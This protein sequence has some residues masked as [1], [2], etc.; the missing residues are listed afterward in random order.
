VPDL[1]LVAFQ[2]DAATAGR[3]QMRAL[4]VALCPEAADALSAL[5]TP[6]ELQTNI[7]DHG[8]LESAAGE[9]LVRFEQVAEL[10]RVAIDRQTTWRSLDAHYYAVLTL[11]D[12]LTFAVL[13]LR[14]L[15]EMHR[16]RVVTFFRCWPLSSGA[17]VPG[18]EDSIWS[19]LCAWLAEAPDD[20][21]PD[22]ARGVRW[23]AV[24]STASRFGVRD[25]IRRQNA[26][27]S[28]LAYLREVRAL[29][30]RIRQWRAVL[31]VL[32]RRPVRAARAPAAARMLVLGAPPDIGVIREA[33]GQQVDLWHWE[34]ETPAPVG[35]PGRLVLDAP[36]LIDPEASARVSAAVTRAL[37]SPL[38]TIHGV[39]IAAVGGPAW[40]ALLRETPRTFELFRS[41]QAYLAAL[42]PDLIVHGELGMP[43]WTRTMVEAAWSLGL[44][45]AFQQWGGNYGYIDQRYLDQGELRSNHVLAYTDHVAERLTRQVSAS[46]QARATIHVGG[47]PYL[48]RERE[49]LRLAAEH[50][51]GAERRCVYVPAAFTGSTRYGPSH[52]V[53]DSLQYQVQQR[54]VS[55]LAAVKRPFVVKLTPRRRAAFEPLERSIRRRHLPVSFDRRP[56]EH[57]LDT[58]A[59]WIVDGSATTLQQVLLS[60]NPVIFVDT[61][62]TRFDAG[63]MA[64]L[65][66]DAVV[67][68]A[69][70]V[71]FVDALRDAV[72]DA[73]TQPWQACGE[74]VRTYGVAAASAHDICAGAVE[75]LARLAGA[76]DRPVHA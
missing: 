68:D 30:G 11:M 2:E 55:A 46:R 65:Q 40:Q 49:R 18:P 70:D 42:A 52:A 9:N 7:D 69:W 29:S 57:V 26:D 76:P 33:L 37:A 21:R 58:P 13:Q 75:V 72:L 3:N 47:A 54:V 25:R 28:P 43:R 27:G 6:Y 44:P 5:G 74:F 15:V 61:R 39:P 41:A 12:A 48:A 38:L 36:P 50:R 71:G 35:P 66:G 63:A 16:P 45:T 73:L 8:R 20:R 67:L 32:A 64:A 56:L 17:I 53:D 31:A 19:A 51:M 4:V 14:D 59:V 60:G 22:W 10:S 34:A 24:P 62:G 23:R 1:L